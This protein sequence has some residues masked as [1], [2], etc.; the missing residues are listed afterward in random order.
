[1]ELLVPTKYLKWQSIINDC[2]LC[3]LKHFAMQ[4]DDMWVFYVLSNRRAKHVACEQ[5]SLRRPV[6]QH[7]TKIPNMINM[8]EYKVHQGFQK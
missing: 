3:I 7:N 5:F 1:M 2:D 4:N 8:F 6:K